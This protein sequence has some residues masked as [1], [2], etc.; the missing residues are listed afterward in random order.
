M[1][2]IVIVTRDVGRRAENLIVAGGSGTILKGVELLL[3]EN[4][5]IAGDVKPGPNQI[6]CSTLLKKGLNTLQSMP[7]ELLGIDFNSGTMD[8]RKAYKKLALKYHP[9]KNPKTTPLFQLIQNIQTRLTDSTE[10]QKEVQQA[11]AVQRQNQA[12]KE[13]ANAYSQ[14]REDPQAQAKPNFPPP[15]P[16]PSAYQQYQQHYQQYQQQQQQQ[17]YQYGAAGAGAGYRAA[18]AA[19][20]GAGGAGVGGFN[21]YD[22]AANSRADDY[23]RKNYYEDLL[24]EQYR[25]AAEAEKRAKEYA[26][27]FQNDDV[28]SAYANNNNNNNNPKPTRPSYPPTDSA[29][30]NKQTDPPLNS[31]KTNPKQSNANYQPSSQQPSQ[32]QQQQNQYKYNTNNNPDTNEKYTTGQTYRTTADGKVYPQQQYNQQPANKESSSSATT[33]DNNASKQPSSSSNPSQPTES[34][35]YNYSYNPAT[36]NNTSS[37]GTPTN[38]NN[39]NTAN[40]SKPTGPTTMIPRPFAFKIV[41][42]SAAMV[43]LEWKTSSFHHCPLAVELSWRQNQQLKQASGSE[44]RNVWEMSSKLIRSGVC[45]KKNLI[46]GMTYEF[47]VRSVEEYD[48]GQV[49][50]KSEWTESILTTLPPLTNEGPTP[51]P[52]EILRNQPAQQSQKHSSSS[53]KEKKV[54]PEKQQEKASVATNA[55]ASTSSVQSNGNNKGK[56]KEEDDVSSIRSNPVK[57]RPN[58][59]NDDDSSVNG[60]KR[61][62]RFRRFDSKFGEEEKKKSPKHSSISPSPSLQLPLN[63]I[64]QQRKEDERRERRSAEG[65]RSRQKTE[66]SSNSPFDAADARKQFQQHGK[67]PSYLSASA[68]LAWGKET[69]GTA[70][71]T[72]ENPD[73]FGLNDDDFTYLEV[74]EE[75]DEAD[76]EAGGKRKRGH[77]PRKRDSVDSVAATVEDE[78]EVKERERK[79]NKKKITKKHKDKEKEKETNRKDTDKD[80]HSY[81]DDFE[82][83][84]DEYYD[85]DDFYDENDGEKNKP[86]EKRNHHNNKPHHDRRHHRR[87]RT[88]PPLQA[89]SIDADEV[90]SEYT[91]SDASSIRHPPNM[92][93]KP[94]K[95]RHSTNTPPDSESEGVNTSN[96]F[97]IEEERIFL[98]YPPKDNTS[99]TSPTPN[100]SHSALRNEASKRIYRHPVHKEPFPRSEVKGYLFV[101]QNVIAC[102]NCG[103]WLRVKI[104]VVARHLIGS[105]NGGHDEWGWCL[106]KDKSHV[107]LRL[108]EGKNKMMKLD[109]DSRNNNKMK[110]N[111]NN[112]SSNGVNSNNNVNKSTSNDTTSTNNSK[113]KS[114][115]RDPSPSP[116]PINSQQTSQ[117]NSNKSTSTNNTNSISTT[118]TTS[119]ERRNSKQSTTASP[120]SLPSP[121]PNGIADSKVYPSFRSPPA[122]KGL[123]RHASSSILNKSLRNI[124]KPAMM[125]P[126]LQKPYKEMQK[127]KGTAVNGSSNIPQQSKNGGGGGSAAVNSGE[128]LDSAR[129]NTVIEEWIECFDEK[130]NVYYFNEKTNESKWEPPEWFEEEDPTTGAKYYVHVTMKD[131]ENIEFHSTWT[132][133]KNYSKLIHLN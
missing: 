112:S 111:N 7:F 43:E 64:H 74:D 133:P 102:A 114:M 108:L 53:S 69:L 5:Y 90:E 89:T 48:N 94:P 75:I 88:S 71:N 91:D 30:N 85:D 8:V 115:V 121:I 42:K 113:M 28:F 39:T 26:N 83:L 34:A 119:T 60:D 44:K 11:A 76:E 104:H 81:Q 116:A 68:R 54:Q 95:A 103:D 70:P 84:D 131:D 107:Y 17:Q 32:Q 24:R 33:N 129:S 124:P 20:G 77:L 40:N 78:E 105:K 49:G 57:S 120:T 98:L 18:G 132:K 22:S 126:Q 21:Y 16:N 97:D 61:N 92:N 82:V 63:Q 4:V 1:S 99:S 122:D 3:Q 46:P 125:N 51:T 19:Y 73:N 127:K 100:D 123:S 52:D 41:N 12:K 50:Q 128:A 2:D 62:M 66:T 130:G 9:D 25:K 23:R 45:R 109:G 65:A 27:K 13:A 56:G 35:K 38:T 6:D 86:D 72:A 96:N 14:Y 110:S 29:K 59:S 10:R 58:D 15:K 36:G 67:I 118:T 80:N 93:G 87:R 106:R 37:T 47:R 55:T 117:Q 79:T 31:Y 101:D